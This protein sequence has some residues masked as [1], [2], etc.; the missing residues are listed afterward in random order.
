MKTFEPESQ[1]GKY[2]II[3]LLGRGGMA[4]VYEA[5]EKSVGRIVAL[6]I[7]PAEFARDEERAQRFKKEIQASAA[8]DHPNIVTVFEVGE[9]EGISYYT[10]SL[11]PGGDLKQKLM[12]NNLSLEKGIEILKQIASGLDY[13][14]NCGFV[15]RDVKPE[16]I[17][18]RNDQTA[19][20][21]DFGIA[22]ATESGTRMTAAGLSIGT[23]HYMSPE[24]AAGKEVDGRS[25]IY[26]LGI[27]FYELLTGS[28][29]F[30]ANESL[31]IGIKHLNDPVP[32]LHGSHAALNPILRKLM[33]K[34]PAD[35]YQTGS[36][37]IA[38]LDQLRS[39]AEIDFLEISQGRVDSDHLI[40]AQKKRSKFR[41]SKGAVWAISG[42]TVGFFSL[43]FIRL[44]IEPDSNV[45]AGGSV[46]SP[47]LVE[48]IDR[49]INTKRSSQN[50]FFSN[51][52]PEYYRNTS[53][54]VP[55]CEELPEFSEQLKGLLV[56]GDILRAHEIFNELSIEKNNSECIKQPTI[57]ASTVVAAILSNREL[58]ELRQIRD[59][60][61]QSVQKADGDINRITQ[62]AELAR[63][64]EDLE[65]FSRASQAI[66]DAKKSREEI[67]ARSDLVSRRIDRIEI[68]SG[69]FIDLTG[70]IK[71]EAS[72][73]QLYQDWFFS[74]VISEDE[75]SNFWSSVGS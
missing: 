59:T 56:D 55:N 28:V 35:R 8:L 30:E 18:F 62:L 13:A 14:H 57:A 50:G 72:N 38:A 42:V 66:I 23:P 68:A 21:A 34:Q 44:I 27:I 48:Q 12:A 49:S 9:I 46:G 60:L 25:D 53:D 10:M 39:G 22:K 40:S 67:K 58:Q 2:R 73:R 16:N 3:Q 75:Y 45:I 5:E 11:L 19:V 43:F 36:E 29:P 52:Q 20:L 61:V 17:L 54:Y 41:L 6:K 64:A 65:G 7:L 51:T 70:L 71:K 33:A 32:Q 1:F 47:R 63:L 26:A 74:G 4:D 31:A 37:L 24:Q 15:H 69:Y